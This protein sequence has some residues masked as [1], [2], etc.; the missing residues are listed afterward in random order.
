M[1]LPSHEVLQDGA[2]S[3]ALSAYHSDLRQVEAAALT[4]AAQGV[5]QAIDQ[6]DKILHPPVAH[7]NG[8]ADLPVGLLWLVRFK[9]LRSTEKKPL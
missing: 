8:E 3:C 1:D 9:R 4:H 2:L 6:R 7:R 5:L